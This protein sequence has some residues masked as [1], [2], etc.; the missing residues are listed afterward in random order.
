MRAADAALSSELG[1]FLATRLR[2]AG[3]QPAAAE[4]QPAPT[5]LLVSDDR[6]F[7]AQLG[8]AAQRGARCVLVS[9]AR[10]ELAPGVEH[11][12]WEH[13]LSLAGSLQG[14]D[15]DEEYDDDDADDDWIR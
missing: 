4:A 11:V 13:V 15:D 1:A 6:G 2:D 5:V 14:G 12:P 10:R 3:E 9:E 7:D 8:G